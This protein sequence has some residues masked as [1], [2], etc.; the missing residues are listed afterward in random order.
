MDKS[1][2]GFGLDQVGNTTPEWANWIFRGWLILSNALTGYI[3]ALAAIKGI[4][5]TPIEVGVIMATLNF[6]NL[7]VYGFSKLFGVVPDQAD[8]AKPLIAD[9]QINKDGS[10][11]VVNPVV[12]EPP[13]AP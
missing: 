10:T 1:K 5:M 13:P 2:T 3:T 7:L 8:P 11:K 9:T 6:L 12:V 4:N